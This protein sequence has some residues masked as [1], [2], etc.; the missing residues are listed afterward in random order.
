M[1]LAFA[2]YIERE[3]ERENRKM[4][5]NLNGVLIQL[6]QCDGTDA[7]CVRHNAPALPVIQEVPAPGHR[8]TAAAV[9]ERASLL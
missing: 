2:Y 4:K 3:R 1:T 7:A 8:R 9:H 5:K 6:L